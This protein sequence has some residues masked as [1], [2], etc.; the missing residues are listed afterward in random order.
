MFTPF[1]YIKTF[2]VSS[3]GTTT[4]EGPYTVHTFTTDSIFTVNQNYTMNYLLVGGGAGGYQGGGGGGQ[5][6]TGSATINVGTYPI[7]IGQGG[8]NQDLQ[9]AGTASWGTATTGLGFTADLGKGASYNAS[10]GTWQGGWNDYIPCTPVIY[11]TY[12]A[13]AGAGAGGCAS[14]SSPN[15]GDG[16][17]VTVANRSAVYYGAGGKSSAGGTN[18]LG[19]GNPG[20]GG[21][22]G[23]SS[24]PLAG[25]EVGQ[26]GIA[27]IW[28]LTN[29]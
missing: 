24:F 26:N 28:Y 3:G 19:Y 4:I 17:A 6:V 20:S 15:G 8:I 14:P 1:A 9:T 13:G 27:I 29:I 18:G 25:N 12:E 21:S 16:V 22:G 2:G 11:N 7:V 23:T 10:F 5:V